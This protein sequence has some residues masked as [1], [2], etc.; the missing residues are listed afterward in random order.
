MTHIIKD[1]LTASRKFTWKKELLEEF[2]KVLFQLLHGKFRPTHFSLQHM[3]CRRTSSSNLDSRSQRRRFQF[4]TFT[5]N[6]LLAELEVSLAG[7][8]HIL[9]TSLKLSCRRSIRA[10]ETARSCM[11]STRLPEASAF[12]TAAWSTAPR[13]STLPTDSKVSGLASQLAPPELSLQTHSC[14]WL[15]NTPRKKCGSTTENDQHIR[16]DKHHIDQ[17]WK[18]ILAIL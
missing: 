8:F 16:W 12:Q 14:S 15:T 3:K 7:S 11:A 1:L 4:R 2:S 6:S 5:S 17:I 9:K 10:E 13:K 18:S